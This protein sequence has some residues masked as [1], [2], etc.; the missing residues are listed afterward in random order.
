MNELF[1]PF[2]MV[3]HVITMY[4]IKFEFVKFLIINNWPFGG[5]K[6]GKKNDLK[7][8]ININLMFCLII[9]SNK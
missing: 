8:T 2:I 6:M 5:W 3:E 4:L 7:A 9:W 1:F